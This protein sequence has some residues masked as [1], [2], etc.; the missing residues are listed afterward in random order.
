MYCEAGLNLRTKRPKRRVAAAHRE[1]R[2]SASNF[3]ECWSM[4]FVSD[5]LFNGRRIRAL[6]VV[7]NFSRACLAIYVDRSIKGSDVVNELERLRLFKGRRPQRIQVDQGP[8]FISK[9]L[10]KWAY[11]H[12]V[13]LDFSR[14]GKPTDNALIESFNGSFRDECLN[15]NWFL[16]LDDA[17][18]KV[19]IW[20]KDYNEFRP[21]SSLGNLTPEEYRKKHLKSPKIS[22]FACLG[23]G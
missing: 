6:T 5:N 19:N 1:Q 18:E 16:S 10:D 2:P 9:D 22:N 11:E 7:D 4:D 21:H 8:E 23:Y 20:R 17:K 3:D 15:T 14:P 12:G 13:T